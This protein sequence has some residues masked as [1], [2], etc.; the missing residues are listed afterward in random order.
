MKS[1][2]WFIV[3]LAWL[4]FFA[5]GR[6]AGQADLGPDPKEVQEVLS[7]AINYLKSQQTAEGGFAPK[8]AGP[9]V[10]A[11]VAAGLVR[12]GVR[13][14]EPLVV[15]TL[16]FLEKNVQ[17]D[18]GIYDKFLANYTTSVA[19]MAFQET[20][21]A[22]YKKVLQNAVK[23]LKGLQFDERTTDEKDKKFGGFGYDGK[24]PPDLSNS[25]FAV[26]ALLASGLSKDD[27]AIKNALKFLNR[28]QNLKGEF[29]DQP[30][31]Q[32]T[33]KDDEGGFVYQPD[34]DDKRHVT[35][36]GGLRSL[37]GMT[38]SGLKSFLY[39]GVSKDDPRVKAAISWVRRH[40][41]LEENPG[42]KQAGL[43]YYY[44]TFAKAMA[45][46]GEDRFTDAAGK[47]HDWRRELFDALKKRQQPDG[48]W[49]NAGDKTF[50]EATPELATAF[51][52]LSLS[53]CQAGKR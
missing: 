25:A 15:R 2:P 38:Y 47:K 37:G 52:L 45:A 8:I 43:Y 42:M 22:R 53:Y 35:P 29:N 5:P 49:R 40:Y 23:F 7:K 41:T 11:L 32:K 12:N 48:S 1:L 18:G 10:S 27:P 50:G 36:A 31:A 33:S 44:H 13:P 21:D 51:A 14:K 6:G 17:P 16:A 28:C 26:E 4:I 9:G 30:F 19:V 24:K 3:S 46:W 20:K 34:P 39:A